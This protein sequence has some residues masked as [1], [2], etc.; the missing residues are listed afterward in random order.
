MDSGK[1]WF[2]K[3]KDFVTTI[4]SGKKK[5]IL[6][7]SSILL[8]AYPNPFNTTITIPFKL[9]RSSQIT[10]NVYNVQG[11]RVK[12]LVSGN[13]NPGEH[14]IKWNGKDAHNSE[15]SSGIYFIQMYDKVNISSQKLLLIK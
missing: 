7:N 3:T 12:T 9:N 15:V 11:K 10:L 5:E 14:S 4:S 13:L 8:P 1:A 6:P 2:Y